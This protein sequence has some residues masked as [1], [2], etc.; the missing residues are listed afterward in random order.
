MSQILPN[1]VLFFVSLSLAIAINDTIFE[2]LMK[3]SIF[4]PFWAF[5]ALFWANENLPEK[6]SSVT[7]ECLRS[8]NFNNKIRKKLMT[9]FEKLTKSPNLGHFRPFL[10][11]FGQ[12]RIFLKNQ[13]LS[14]FSYYGSLTSCKK[15]E[16]T[17]ESI[18]RKLHYRRTHG[19]SWIHRTPPALPGVQK[20]EED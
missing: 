6:S 14:L 17:N 20:E 2:K 1:T 4:R 19:Q 7:F 13:A 18:Q 15:L 12:T 10:P 3:N 9:Q 16:K 8:P 11:F 5:F